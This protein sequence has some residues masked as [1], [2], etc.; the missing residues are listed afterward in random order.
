MFLH[1]DGF[2]LFDESV[3]LIVSKSAFSNNQLTS[4][5]CEGSRVWKSGIWVWHLRWEVVYLER[6]NQMQQ[7]CHGSPVLLHVLTD[8]F[9]G[10]EK[11]RGMGEV[12]GT[13][14]KNMLSVMN[15]IPYGFATCMITSHLFFPLYV[16][17]QWPLTLWQYDN[18][19][20]HVVNV[21]I[22]TMA[23]R[24][25]GSCRAGWY[26]YFITLHHISISP[27]QRANESNEIVFNFTTQ[28]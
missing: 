6:M 23:V 15:V 18:I 5:V 13:Q 21:I 7:F 24:W 12:L 26:S 1:I 17:P 16:T 2:K 4:E 11:T 10:Q 20:W 28:V 22:F 19:D 3:S 14:P 27:P 25:L 9:V 8:V